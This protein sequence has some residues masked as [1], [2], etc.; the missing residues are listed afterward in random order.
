MRTAFFRP[1]RSIRN[2][3]P[4]MFMIAS[5]TYIAVEYTSPP[6]LRTRSLQPR[7]YGRVAVMRTAQSICGTLRA[8]S[9]ILSYSRT[10]TFHLA[11]VVL[12]DGEAAAPFGDGLYAV[13]IRRLW[14]RV[15]TNFHL[16]G[17]GVTINWHKHPPCFS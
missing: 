6:V 17:P 11:G 9:P 13:P 14:H 4:G 8:G 12:Y 1:M 15:A 5:N 10:P 7:P 3:I 16:P 2:S